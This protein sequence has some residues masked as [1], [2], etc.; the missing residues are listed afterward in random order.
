MTVDEL[1]EELMNGDLSREVCIR[2]HESTNRYG[3]HEGRHSISDV[4]LEPM[5]QRSA[6]DDLVPMIVVIKSTGRER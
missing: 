3:I 5:A 2:V 1:I 4:Y 6:G